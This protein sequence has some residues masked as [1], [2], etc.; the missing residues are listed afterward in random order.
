MHLSTIYLS[1][2]LTH[3]IAFWKKRKKQPSRG[4]RCCAAGPIPGL[5]ACRAVRRWVVG[6]ERGRRSCRRRRCYRRRRR[7]YRRRR[8][9]RWWFLAGGWGNGPQGGG[10]HPGREEGWWRS[11]RRS[12]VGGVPAD[13]GKAAV[14]GRRGGALAEDGGDPRGEQAGRS[15]RSAG[16]SWRTAGWSEGR[17]QSGTIVA[18]GWKIW[19]PDDVV[20]FRARLR[21]FSRARL[22]YI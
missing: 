13:D 21:K 17:R 9:S 6:G 19:Q 5:H 8:S 3:V 22:V 14:N 11:G 1:T 12:S 18:L 4:C 15:W 16:H 7:C 10:R 20:S 2:F